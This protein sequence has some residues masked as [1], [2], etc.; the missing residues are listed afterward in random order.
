MN[1]AP[2]PHAAIRALAQY[3]RDHPH[4]SDSTEGIRRWWLP[5]GLSMT[6]DEME[7][8]LTWMKQ[9]R[10]IDD[11]RGADGRVRYRRIAGDAQLDA[12][13]RARD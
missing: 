6:T 9:Q 13:L 1:E 5:L 7:M 2:E 3:L 10:L 8:A 4:A 11:A 12:I